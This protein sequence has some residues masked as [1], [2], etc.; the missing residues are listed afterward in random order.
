MEESGQGF[1]RSRT[2]SFPF[3]ENYLLIYMET[4]YWKHRLQSIDLTWGMCGSWPASPC[5][6][7]TS[8]K[9][10]FPIFFFKMQKRLIIFI[11]L[12]V[13]FI[14]IMHL[15]SYV[16]IDYLSKVM[17][18][19]FINNILPARCNSLGLFQKMMDDRH[20]LQHWDFITAPSSNEI[21]VLLLAY[22]DLHLGL[23]ADAFIQSNLQLVH[24]SEEGETIYRCRYSKDVHRNKCKALTIARL[25]IC[26]IQQ[27]WLG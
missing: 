20:I 19:A 18:C 25:P 23:L 24:L 26:C 12:L 1:K 16:T 3:R 9:L 7:Y 10:T 2:L 4:G 5:V 21:F 15:Y 27:R 14:G 17:S 8:K 22:C 13:Y 11:Y 6:L